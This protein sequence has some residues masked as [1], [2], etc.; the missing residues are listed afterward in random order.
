MSA[1]IGI[2]NRDACLAQGTDLA[3]MLVALAHRG[4]DGTSQWRDGPVGLGH[5]MLQTTPEACY[6]HLPLTWPDAGVT[7]TADVRLDNRFELI[8]GLRMHDRPAELI[9]DS[10]LILAAYRRWGERCVEHLLGDFAFAIWDSRTQT[11]F[12]A[13]DHFGVLPFYYYLSSQLF[14]FATEIRALF[15]LPQV[16]RMISEL[17]VAEYL[18]GMFGA[19]D[20]TFYQ[21]IR[22]LPPAHTLSVCADGVQ[23]RRYW[24]LDPERELCLSTDKAYADAFRAIFTT[25]VHSRLRSSGAVGTLLSGGLDSSSITCVARER[26]I[27]MGSQARLPTFSAIFDVVP[28]CDERPYINAVLAQ[29]GLE[30]HYIHGDQSGP[31]RH[32]ERLVWHIEEP[33]LAPGLFLNWLLYQSIAERGLRVLLDGDDGDGVVSHGDGY[34]I[35]LA[36]TGRW[37]PLAWELYQASRVTG[38]SFPSLLVRFAWRFRL[39]SVAVQSRVLAPARQLWRSG[40]GLI[41]RRAA[42]TAPP[43]QGLLDADFAARTHIVERWQL[44]RE[45]QRHVPKTERGRHYA[46][47]TDLRKVRALEVINKTSAAFGI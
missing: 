34:L 14:T 35:E 30:P 23:L 19:A 21:E 42:P 25:A 36:S 33:F 6:E 29:G 45:Q 27:R 43:W 2:Y 37:L 47:L 1:I 26:L 44:Q 22:R 32:I 3:A 13:R 12:C 7:I 46:E 9:T 20:S 16:P 11:I 41:P 17:A 38:E 24:A 10:E 39:R 31:L 4:P 28:E 15:C 18:T 40:V 5:C 8:A